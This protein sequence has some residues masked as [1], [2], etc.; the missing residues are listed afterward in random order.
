MFVIDKHCFSTETD[1]YITWLQ[2][3]GRKTVFIEWQT[4]FIAQKVSF[5]RYT[6]LMW[7]T[8]FLSRDKQCF[9]TKTLQS[10][11]CQGLTRETVFIND[12]H[13]FSSQS[14]ISS[15]KQGFIRETVFVT[16]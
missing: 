2:G 10:L 6:E 16:W 11:D 12:K 8:L 4:L 9:S 1:M 14:M 15:D 3:L 13:C 7:E 5:I